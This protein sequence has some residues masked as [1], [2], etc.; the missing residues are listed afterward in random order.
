M[1]K[2]RVAR[3]TG[4]ATGLANAAH[5][6]KGTVVYLGA[7][8]AADATQRVEQ[9][10]RSGPPPPSCR[11]RNDSRHGQKHQRA[12]LGNRRRALRSSRW[13]A[14]ADKP[15]PRQTGETLPTVRLDPSSNA[16]AVG[17]DQRAV[18]KTVVPPCKCSSR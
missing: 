18:L 4:N 12:R 5:R 15:C 16:W 14:A 7:H 9:I 6:L 10:G 13:R 17:D 2:M 1:E 3:S 11:H 8:S